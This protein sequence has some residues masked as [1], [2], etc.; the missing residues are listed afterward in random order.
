MKNETTLQPIRL[1]YRKLSGNLYEV[2]LNEN[3]ITEQIQHEDT[4]ETIYI[5]DRYS[6]VV[7]VDNNGDLIVGLIRLK[8]TQDDEYALINKGIANN[9]DIDYL[10]YREYVSECKNKVKL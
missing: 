8:Y 2:E 5:R 7:R 6:S 1:S 4:T 9:Q 10:A 3:I